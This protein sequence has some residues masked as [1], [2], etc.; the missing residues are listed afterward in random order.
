ML[1]SDIL[2]RIDVPSIDITGISSDSRNIQPG[3]LFIA[4]HGSKFDG[5]SFARDAINAG[6]VAVCAERERPPGLLVPWVTEHDVAQ[7]QAEFAARFFHNPSKQLNII[8]VTGTNGKSSVAYGIANLFESAALMGTIGWGLP[9]SLRD[10][11]LT[12][13]GSIDLQSGLAQLIERDVRHVAMEVSSHALEQGRVNCV[14]FDGAV[15]TNLTRDHLDFHKTMRNYADAKLKLFENPKLRFGVVNS[16]DEFGQVIAD[17]LRQRNI[18]CFT[19][20]NQSSADLSWSDVRH[21]SKGVCGRW[22]GQWGS[23]EFSLPYYGRMYVAN[24]AAILLTALGHD[25][26]FS[27]AV[28][29]MGDLRPIPG[30]MEF[31]KRQGRLTVV[32]D[33]AH[34]PDALRHALVAVRAHV[35]GR[36]FC[37][38]GCGGDRD[39]GKRPEM[40]R[41]AE[42]LADRIYIT[43][44]NPRNEQPE[45]IVDD[46]LQGV[47]DLDSAVIELDRR[48]A[49]QL[50]MD[51]GTSQDVVL[52]AGKGRERYQTNRGEGILC[53]DRTV[54][55]ETLNGEH[56]C[57]CG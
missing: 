7:R 23:V 5:H 48:T 20:G 33:Y 55:E 25:W 35:Q 50:A 8:G 52:I 53:D 9:G 24:A 16:D 22:R 6:A 1:L 3:D 14:E 29:Q 40:G 46:I 57:Y 42:M 45:S 28:E 44:D 2:G 13:M 10:T 56:L 51:A 4:Y 32:I 34:T 19:F 30:R 21:T 17:Y 38:F 36:V 11:S 54:V 26:K 49:I 15:F 12:T 41:I 39:A 31:I 27:D 43:S 47:T 18:K 37:V